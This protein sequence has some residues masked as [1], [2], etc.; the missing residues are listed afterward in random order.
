METPAMA[1]T[2][3][4]PAVKDATMSLLG[5]MMNITV[6]ILP[7]KLAEETVSF[8]YICPDEDEPVKPKQMYVHPDDVDKDT[9]PI[10]MWASGELDHAREVDGILHRVTK[11]EMDAAREAVL[12]PKEI[13]LSIF[14]ADEVEAVA[15]PGGALYRVRPKASPHVYAM[16]LDAVEKATN[17]AFIG[18]MTI[19]GKQRMYRLLAWNRNLILQEQ[20]RPGEFYDPEDYTHEYPSKLLD[21]FIA[22]V[23]AQTETF[24]PEAYA[25]FLRDRAKEIDDAK[26]DPNAPKATPAKPVRVA[27]D[28]S[29]ALMAMLEGL[30]SK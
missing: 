3:S 29:D 20:I 6:D 19:R 12:P 10:R 28:D 16:I 1:N 7:A 21:S 13:A 17:K 14:P 18:E 8:P 23:D 24:D 9:G 2:V 4:K 11:A 27:K 26:R 25:N 5:G 15:R 22:A 30:A